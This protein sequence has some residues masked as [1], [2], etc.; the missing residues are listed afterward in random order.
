MPG[1]RVGR[2]GSLL[3]PV[4]PLPDDAPQDEAGPPTT[5]P[6]ADLPVAPKRT[7]PPS[8][9]RLNDAAGRELWEAYRQALVLQPGLSYRAFASHVVR[10]GLQP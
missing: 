8:T 1:R 9:I 4:A 6:L 10:R 3:G 5:G 7:T 2:P